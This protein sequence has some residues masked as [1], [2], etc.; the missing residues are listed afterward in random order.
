M[1]EQD[2]AKVLTGTLS[3]VNFTNTV[4]E[5]FFRSG[6][7]EGM[8]S[9]GFLAAALGESGLAAGM[10]SMS[11]EEMSDQVCVVSFDLDGNHVEGMLW[12]WPFKDGDVVQAVVEQLKTEAM[13]VSQ[14]QIQKRRLSPFIHTSQLAREHIGVR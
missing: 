7:R 8:A 14:L 1:G 13:F 9:A 5:V 10:T 12:N 3:N 2:F 11:M 6:D 4:A